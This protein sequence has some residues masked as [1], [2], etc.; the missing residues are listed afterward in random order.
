M[1]RKA[2]LTTALSL[3]VSAA[4]GGFLTFEASGANPAAITSTR[5]AFRT[6]VGGGTTAGANGSFGGMRREINWDGVPNSFA[7]SNFLP[8]NFFN[9]N[10]PRGAVF[11]TPGSGFM[12]STNAGESSSALFG[13]SSDFQTFSAQR[14]FTA[15]DSSI[16]DVHFFVPG[17]N[18]AATTS[19][20]GLIFVDVEVENLTKLEFFDQNDAL[21]FSRNALVFGNQGLTFLGGVANAG[22]SISRVRITSGQNI[23]VSNGRLG[24]PND[25][26]VVMDD[27]LYA[28]PVQLQRVPEPPTFALLFLGLLALFNRRRLRLGKFGRNV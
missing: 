1:L 21:I 14:L 24:N 28:E 12:V 3:S 7:D 17:T 8:A 18:T 9:V 2:L 5:N 22:E 26:V 13:F 10:S 20:F 23:I 11:S 25:D 27:F 6:A 15:I 16:T 4:H 19:A